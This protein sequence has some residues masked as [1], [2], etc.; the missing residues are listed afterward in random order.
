MN[1]NIILSKDKRKEK[2]I[3]KSDEEGK[4]GKK[5]EKI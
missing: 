1:K 4:K 2:T 5:R 3:N